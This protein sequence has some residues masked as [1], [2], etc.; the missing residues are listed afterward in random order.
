[1]QMEVQ[2]QL[3]EQLEVCI[4]L[5]YELFYWILA[6]SSLKDCRACAY[7]LASS[8]KLH[9]CAYLLASY[10]KLTSAFLFLQFPLELGF[11]CFLFLNRKG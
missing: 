2:K 1:M 11:P 6:S 3:H 9:A 8:F 4:M 5:F 7:L 10:F